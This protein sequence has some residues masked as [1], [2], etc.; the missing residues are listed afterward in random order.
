MVEKD[1]RSDF[2]KIGAMD[3][4][5]CKTR[6]SKMNEAK[7]SNQSSNVDDSSRV[8]WTREFMDKVHRSNERHKQQ[9]CK[10]QGKRMDKKTLALD[11][12]VLSF[13]VDEENKEQSR[14]TQSK[15]DGITTAPENFSEEELDYED[16]LS[17]DDGFEVLTVDDDHELEQVD[18]DKQP[19][20]SLQNEV[21]TEKGSNLDLSKLTEDQLM[22][23]PILQRMMQKF[24][25]D[26]FKNIQKG[27]DAKGETGDV[28][29]LLLQGRLKIGTKRSNLPLIQPYM[30]PHYREN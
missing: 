10:K 1:V 18:S 12:N 2:D 14:N 6:S 17:I 29:I 4:K 19:S 25:N 13:Q 11:A 16:D 30:L 7:C 21:V 24:F 26:Q 20:C 8:Q 22:S 9:N 5:G 28:S 3:A 27:D 15:G 23:N